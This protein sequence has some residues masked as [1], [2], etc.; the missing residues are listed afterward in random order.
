MNAFFKSEF[1][2]SHSWQR[3]PN[4]LFYEDP[5]ILSTLPFFKF[6][7]TLYKGGKGGFNYDSPLV[8]MSHNRANNGKINKIS[9]VGK[10][11]LCFCSR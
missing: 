6:C 3:V 2:Y 4:P 5:S 7:P 9:T 10:R 11:W 1:S 8:W